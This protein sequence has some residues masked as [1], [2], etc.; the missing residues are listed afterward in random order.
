MRKLHTVPQRVGKILLTTLFTIAFSTAFA[1]EEKEEVQAIT[2]HSRPLQ[3]VGN[4]FESIW[5]ID[6]QTVIVPLR[7]TFEF[8]IQHRFGTMGNGYNDFLGLYAPSN[9]RIGFG[10]TPI[11]NL[12]IGFAFTKERL[13]W[14]FNI[15]Y[16]ILKEHGARNFPVSV[17]YYGNVAV[18]TREKE[19]F[20]VY[21]NASDRFS[22][23][24]QLMVAR[25]LTRDFS[26]QGSINLSHMNW[27]DGYV[28]PEGDIKGKMKNDHFSTTLMGRYKISDAFAF[29]ANYDQPIT[30]HPVNNPKPN[31][32][33]GV[34]LATPLHAFQVFVG[35]YQW[36][37]PQYNN[38]YNPNNY[39]D[40]WDGFLI[41]FNITRLLDAQEEN[42]GDMM[43]KRKRK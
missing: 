32:S 33:L 1:Q 38:F 28:N 29:M 34:E 14:D 26:V 15:K 2:I 43:F 7:K 22:Y 37:V 9:I 17:T 25:K 19:K 35:N 18:D 12:M 21:T 6:N 4:T 16:A 11:N 40:T 24:H 23:F 5:L 39:Q 10:Y 30:K 31:L 8:D 36:L 20:T 41:G 13:L 42:L 27:V 3:R